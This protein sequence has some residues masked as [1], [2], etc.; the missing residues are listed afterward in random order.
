MVFITINQE[1]LLN[2]QSDIVIGLQFGDEG[3]GKVVYHLIK[4]EKYD[5]CVRYNGG[6][7]AGHTIY[8]DG[9]KVV[10]H[11]IP[12]GALHS[13]P[14]LIGS[15]C[16]VDPRKLE[17]E[18][19][20]C[21]E[22]GVTNIRDLVKVAYNCHI[23]QEKHID[24]DKKSDKVGSTHCGMGPAYSDKY[25]RTGV[26]VYDTFGDTICGCEVVK[27]TEYLYSIPNAKILF[28]GAQGYLLDINWGMYPYVTSTHCDTGYITSTGVSPRTISDVFGV[29]KIYTTYVG[30]MKYQPDD[31]IFNKLGTLGGEFGATTGRKRQCNWMD[32]NL[33]INAVKVN[34]VNKLIINKCD[35]LEQL[36][37][38]KLYDHEEVNFDSLDLMKKYIIDRF[39]ELSSTL[40]KIEVIFFCIP[41]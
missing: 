15:S 32:L 12:S 5:F 4:N 2:M 6:P 37:T 25:R 36:G 39:N 29:A 16:M 11:Q 8:V 9:K 34:G 23:I 26:R 14:S 31:E 21:E 41:S 35:I 19:K 40:G 18:L 10:T 30:T 28:E 38:F 7:N 22:V 1:Y 33:L 13:I 3:K 17:D 24:D 20:M 27:P